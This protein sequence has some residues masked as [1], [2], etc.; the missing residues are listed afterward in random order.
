MAQ[1]GGIASASSVMSPKVKGL[2]ECTAGGDDCWPNANPSEFLSSVKA[3]R[4]AADAIESSD[5]V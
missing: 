5:F 2:S 4:Q 3:H 1:K